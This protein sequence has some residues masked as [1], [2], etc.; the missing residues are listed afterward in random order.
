MIMLYKSVIHTKLDYASPL[1][2]SASSSPLQKLEKFQNKSIRFII[3]ALNSTPSPALGAETGIM[4]LQYRRNYQ[5][6][7][8]LARS[9]TQTSF[10]LHQQ[11]LN[12]SSNSRFAHFRPPLLCK[13]VKLILTLK[14]FTPQPHHTYRQAHHPF[15]QIFQKATLHLLQKSKTMSP[16][17]QFQ[18]LI[19]LTLHPNIHR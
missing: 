18:P 2:G 13:K 9:L 7:R 15:H 6:D 1:Y 17:T 3:G 19:M 10:A 12:I 8:F 11:L 5:T 14:P 16:Q 4:P